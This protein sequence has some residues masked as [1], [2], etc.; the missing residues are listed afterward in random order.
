[1]NEILPGTPPCN[2]QSYKDCI[3]HCHAMLWG[4]N[5][6]SNLCYTI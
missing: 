4:L 1:M 3:L 6:F 5:K 2:K